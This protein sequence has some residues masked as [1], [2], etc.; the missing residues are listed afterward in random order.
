MWLAYT[1]ALDWASKTH[2]R[3]PAGWADHHQPVA[4]EQGRQA[5]PL[6]WRVKATDHSDDGLAH[7]PL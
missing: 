4:A 1:P 2:P 7:R 3:Q 5:V 6:D